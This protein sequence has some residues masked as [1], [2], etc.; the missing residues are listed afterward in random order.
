MQEGL[1]YLAYTLPI[2]A[3]A[4]Y[5]AK[6]MG[7]S[8]FDEVWSRPDWHNLALHTISLRKERNSLQFGVADSTNSYSG[9]MPYIFNS[10]NDTNIKSALKW[11]YD[12]TMGINSSS[13]I[14]DGKDKNAALFYYPYEIP[15]QHPSIAFPRSTSM[16]SDNV[17]GFY[18]F[19]NR[20]RDENDV[21]IAVMNRNR[22]HRGWNGNEA[23]GLSII[24]HNTTWARMPGK[25][26]KLYN[27][28][29]K[30]STPLIDGWPREP[31][32]GNKQ[33]YTRVVKVFNGQ[34]GG[35]VSIDSSVNF[36]ITLAQRDILVD[37]IKRGSIDTIIAINDHF[38]D[39][40][41]HAWHWQL[42]P[43]PAETNM[44]LGNENNLSTFTIRGR[45][46]SWLKGWLY[47]YRDADY[48]NTEEVLRIIK[49]GFNANFKIVM[50]L[51]IG[52]E[53]LAN[54]IATGL[55][56]ANICINFDTLV[57]G[58]QVIFN[59]HSLPFFFIYHSF[60]V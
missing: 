35:Y 13:P 33:G 6:S 30:F 36:N 9:F 20:Y 15:A 34:G 32:K 38:A 18:E 24:S 42:S 8:T 1:G 27:L 49:Y 22:R 53:P 39:S 25:E 47:N 10:T 5:L 17:D 56:I 37:M 7:I 23:F 40:L 45:N 41:S 2:L 58:L 43:N 16:I 59:I 54:R 4:V 28:T 31:P 50:A 3:P 29:R 19:R 14:Y 26:F 44:T 57:Q 60:S 12:R 46:G 52:S 51:G 11:L 48:N 55:M 21:L